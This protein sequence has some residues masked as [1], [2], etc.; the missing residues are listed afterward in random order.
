[1]NRRKFL[2]KAFAVGA[3]LAVTGGAP[4]SL[5]K[6]DPLVNKPVYLPVVNQGGPPPRTSTLKNIVFLHHSVGVGLVETGDMRG[7][8]TTAGYSLWDQ[9]YNS[10]GLRGP[11]G[12]TAG[13]IYS[14]PDDNTN[15]DGLAAVFAQTYHAAP[16]TGAP[17]NAF[18]GLMRHEVVILKSCYLAIEQIYDPDTYEMYIP[19][20]LSLRDRIDQYPNKAFIFLTAPPVNS[21]SYAAG[22]AGYNGRGLAN[23]MTSSAFI[24]SSHPNLF[25]YDFFNQLAYPTNAPQNA[26][27]LKTDY[28]KRDPDTNAL[29]DDSHP[30]DYADQT[31]T[32][33]IVNYID[34]V[35][36][37]FTPG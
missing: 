33:L 10:D 25:V 23:W 36:Q 20:Y 4:Q 8:L 19:Y 32:P 22:A 11:D 13:Y 6:A 26:N 3:S 2:Q 9:S 12:S 30:N 27:L 5:A 14:V 18:S 17:Y 37:N 21:L 31:I 29:L 7:L 28:Q 24:G 15:P 1:M 16:A 34:Q 35:L